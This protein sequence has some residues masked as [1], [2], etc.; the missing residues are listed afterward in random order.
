MNFIDFF[1]KED[2]FLPVPAY[3]CVFMLVYAH[4]LGS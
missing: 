4:S 2:T 1:F 3:K